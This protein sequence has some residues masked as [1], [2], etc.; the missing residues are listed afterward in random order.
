MD[1]R[2]FPQQGAW[3]M[4]RQELSGFSVSCAKSHSSSSSVSSACLAEAPLM[5]LRPVGDETLVGKPPGAQA[6]CPVIDEYPSTKGVAN[7]PVALL[8]M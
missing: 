6:V 5:K 2:P 4:T 8:P 3:V 7:A 1:N